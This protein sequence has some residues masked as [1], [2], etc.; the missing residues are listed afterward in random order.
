[1]S[2]PLPTSRLPITRLTARMR[3]GFSKIS[4]KR[5]ENIA[6]DATSTANTGANEAASNRYC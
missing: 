2:A 5:C 3:T 6:I 1:M 4:R